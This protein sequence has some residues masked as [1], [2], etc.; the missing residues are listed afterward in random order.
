MKNKCLYIIEQYNTLIWEVN[1]WYL[2]YLDD[3]ELFNPYHC[4]H[5]SSMIDNY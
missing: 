5:N 4:D 3:R 1:I 2:V